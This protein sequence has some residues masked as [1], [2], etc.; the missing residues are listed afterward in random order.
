LA[1]HLRDKAPDTSRPCA[2]DTRRS[3][4][5]NTLLK[6]ATAKPPRPYYL[7]LTGRDASSHPTR[8]LR[9]QTVD[10]R[11]TSSHPTLTRGL[12]LDPLSSGRSPLQPSYTRGLALDPLSSGRSRGWGRASAPRC[13][14]PSSSARHSP[15]PA[16]KERATSEFWIVCGIPCSGSEAG[17]YLRLMDLVYHS[18]LGLRVIK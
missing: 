1:R 4:S 5:S 3:C 11:D 10:G 17:S 9:P 8:D 12:A 14:C 13:Q 15:Q 18:T 16:R 2:C 7:L 6:K